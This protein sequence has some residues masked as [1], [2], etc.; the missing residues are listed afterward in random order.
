M[1]IEYNEKILAYFTY[2]NPFNF[3]GENDA[4]IFC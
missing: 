2:P 3:N 1:S 4:S